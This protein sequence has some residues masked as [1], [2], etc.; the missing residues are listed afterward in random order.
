MEEGAIAFDINGLYCLISLSIIY[1]GL[2]FASAD[3]LIARKLKVLSET[4]SIL[5]DVF[6]FLECLYLLIHSHELF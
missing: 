2:L 1:K 3:P 6:T 4:K 5:D